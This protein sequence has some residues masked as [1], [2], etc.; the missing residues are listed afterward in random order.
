MSCPLIGHVGRDPNSPHKNVVKCCED[1]MNQSRH[2]D[3]L[4]E[5]QVS[6]EMKNSRL[7]LKILIE[8][9]HDE[10]PDSKNKGDIIEL[11]KFLTSYNDQVNG[12]VME[13]ALHNAKYTSLKIQKE[14]LHIFADKVRNVIREEIGDVK[15]CILIGEA[16]DE[17]KKEQM[18]IILRFVD[19]DGF[20]REPFFHIV[21]VKDTMALT[22]KNEIYV[23]LSRYDLQIENIRGQGYDGE[24]NMVRSH[25]HQFFV[26]L[27]F[28]I[29]IVVGSSKCHNELQSAQAAEIESLIASIEIETR[30]GA[31]KMGTLQRAG[32]TRCG[33]HFQSVC[34][35]I[36]MFSA[37]CSVINTIS[38]E[39]SNYSQRGDAEAAYMI[40]CAMSLVS[41][42][43]VL[44][45]NLRDDGWE[46]LLID[47]KSF[48]EK[49]QIDIPDMNDQYTGA[50][51]K[52]H[53]QIDK[54]TEHHFRIDIFTA[55]VD[56]Q[57]QE[58]NNRFNDHTIDL[59]IL[60]KFLLR[61]QL[62]HYDLH[63]PTHL[64]FQDMSTL[65]ELC[66]RLA[67]LEK[68][69]IYYLIDRLIHLVLTLPVST[70][71]TE[72][73]FSVMKLIKT[74]LRTRMEDEFLAD[75]LLVYIEKEIAKN[76]TLE[77]I[78]DEFYSMKNRCR[79]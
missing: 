1:L 3:K 77:M 46:S 69:K 44:I 70:A 36:R 64:D 22:L 43:K 12:V 11:I 68:S 74:R 47:V 76:F 60:K 6:Q 4:V 30:K 32:D 61:I 9:G 57:L 66:R 41:T 73:A 50:R 65:S 55:A 10:S 17:S 28:I 35:L 15:F 53:R 29:N 59:F 63:V 51:D 62:Q 67:I 72:R 54:S 25:V 23:L 31:N 58:L 21:H 14:I 37:T 19:N 13:N 52:S 34:S 8:V 40:L 33:S 49:H 48:C 42:M 79:A 78:M 5:K 18:A 56:F 7:R 38:N 45:Q 27:T 75:H 26:H 39:I 20:I 2:I 71:T 24:S 16:W